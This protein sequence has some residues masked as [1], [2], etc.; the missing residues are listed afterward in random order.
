MSEKLLGYYSA[1]AEQV[2][3]HPQ[4]IKSY[5]QVGPNGERV[6]AWF[7]SHERATELYGWEDKVFVGEFDPNTFQMVCLNPCGY[8]FF[9]DMIDE[10]WEEYP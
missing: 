7:H 2:L 5:V 8:E 3:G 1:Q 9:T 4:G 6:M 10:E